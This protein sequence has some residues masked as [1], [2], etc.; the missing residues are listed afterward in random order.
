MAT[1]ANLDI[2]LRANLKRFTEPFKGASKLVKQFGPIVLKAAAAATAAFA[3]MSA[4]VAGLASAG[5]TI[6]KISARTQIA[7]KDVQSLTFAFE[8]NGGS[9]SDLEAAVR[10]LN[11]NLLD[12]QRGTMTAV[13]NFRDLGIQFSDIANLSQA[14]RF[15]AVAKAL[16]SIE[17]ESIRS[18]LAMKVFGRTA[19]TLLPLITNIDELEKQFNALGLTLSDDQVKAAARVT[20]QWNILRLS[21][22][23]LNANIGEIFIP[24]ISKGIDLFV[25]LAPLISETVVPV[26]RVFG[27]IVTWA[28]DKVGFLI[29]Q[30]GRLREVLAGAAI[31]GFFG[32]P[33]G[34]AI[35]SVALPLVSE[36]G[37]AV[38]G[39]AK[40]DNSVEKITTELKA[41]N[42][43]VEETEKVAKSQEK[44]LKA[45]ARHTA[46]LPPSL[47]AGQAE[48]LSFINRLR[49]EDSN[50]K[51]VDELKKLNNVEEDTLFEIRKRRRLQTAFVLRPV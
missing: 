20:D 43:A 29:R 8:Q 42:T 32:G 41:I 50:R 14:D 40:A 27:A 39:S 33:L 47:K 25:E 17:D 36:L 2:N 6:D 34:A 26:F 46:E 23:K 51:I 5:D 7:A 21:L 28:A 48:T 3:G 37:R 35:G 16:G 4:S 1:I 24:L 10:G 30:M 9:A 44:E 15:R 22:R 11:R 49:R 12:L 45:I 19:T 18:G 13:D 31:G 38:G